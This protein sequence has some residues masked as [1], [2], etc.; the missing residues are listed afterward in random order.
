MPSYRTEGIILKRTNFSEADKI[1]TIFSKHY[2]KI[3]VLAKGVRRINS[4]RGG[5]VELFNQAVLFLAEGKNF[6]ILTEAQVLNS[7][8]GLRSDLQKI[9][10]AYYVCELVDRLCAEGQENRKVYELLVEKL[11]EI[12]RLPAGRHGQLSDKIN[13]REF[14]IELLKLLG[15]WSE[16]LEGKYEPRAY[17]EEL[18]ERKLKSPKFLEEVRKDQP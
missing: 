2:G 7:F 17:I 6:D 18:I 8:R 3:K 12:S 1:L 16:E 4:R 14:E 11:S 15:F 10:K 5:N 13:L 9:G